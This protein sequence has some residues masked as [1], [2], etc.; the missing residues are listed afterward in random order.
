MTVPAKTHKGW[1]NIVTG[2]AKHQLKSLA[3]KVLLG[4]LVSIVQADPSPATINDAISQLHDLFVKNAHIPSVQE[5][6][7]T[8]FG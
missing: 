3:A 6:L 1:A 7:K 8:I 5:D 4:R 2:K